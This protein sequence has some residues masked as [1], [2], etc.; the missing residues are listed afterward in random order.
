MDSLPDDEPMDDPL[1]SAGSIPL[2]PILRVDDGQ[3]DPVALATWHEALSNTLAIEVPHDLMALW[4]YP[5]EGGVVLLGPAELAQDDLAV[6]LPSPRLK[7]EQLAGLEEI[8]RKAGY[9]SASC[10]PVK[11]GK[12]E[13]ALL[14]VANL[15]SGR[16]GSGERVLLQCVTQRIAPMLGRIAR[17]WKPAEGKSLQLQER[18]AGLLTTVAQANRDAGTPHRFVATLSQALGSLLPHDHIELLLPDSSGTKYYRLAEHHGGPLWTDDSLTISA[19]HLDIATIFG[20]R[21]RILVADTYE[22]DRWPRGYLTAHEPAG[23]EIRAVIGAR[24]TLRGESSAYL[25]IGSI[26]PD[27][28]SDED[29]ELLILL[30][31]LISPQISG[32]LEP[33][34]PEPVAAA[35][36]LEAPSPVEPPETAAAPALAQRSP[37][38][39]LLLRIAGILATTTDWSVATQLV[40]AESVNLLPCDKLAI[41]LR[42]TGGDRVVVLEP[43]E[44]RP[45]SGLPLVGVAG[46][47]L[48]RVLQ[49]SS[50][51]AFEQHGSETRLTVPL[52]V[53]GRIYGALTFTALSPKL[54]TEHQVVTVQHLADLIAP[55]CELLRRGSMQPHPT[56]SRYRS[57]Q[58]SVV[59]RQSSVSGD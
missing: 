21:S 48:A 44:R 51:C 2:V 15:E 3:L 37:G 59:G 13:V 39:E 40:A 22:D 43:G 49:G 14:L 11:F 19:E 9:A 10:H 31:G 23:A 27:L 54:L 45:L 58:S 18:L 16:Y 47:S 33:E 32:F 5:A 53:A 12:R 25:L 56:V 42:V 1:V 34:Q 57:R 8:V 28:Y 41:A 52:R 24:L 35:A 50:P 46:T 30:A 4:L 6:P 20:S 36:P 26:G 29:V 38:D 55:H 7:P 17:Q